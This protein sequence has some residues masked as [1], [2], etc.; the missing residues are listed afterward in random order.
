MTDTDSII[1]RADVR[2]L[3]RKKYGAAAL[4]VLNG[5]GAAC[6]GGIGMRGASNSCCGGDVITGGLYDGVDAA[7][8]PEAA[9]LAS[10][11]CGNPTA[12]A[13]LNAGEIVMDLGSGGGIDVLLS[14]RRVGPTGFAYGLDMTDEM[15]TLAE[16]NKAEAGVVNVAFL[17][18]HI[19]QIP[20]PANTVDVII[21]NCVINLSADKDAVL[22][23]AF[24]VLK[25]SGRFAVSD[26]VVEGELPSA[27]RADMEAYVGCV[28]GALE[29]S[30]YLRRLAAAGFEDASIEP[31]RRYTFADLEATTCCSPDVAALP[32]DEKAALDGRV[33]GAFIR[34]VKPKQG[35][36][37][38]NGS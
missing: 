32:A 19:E 26:V 27:V 23:E 2:A 1:A 16:K 21:S 33:M 37:E 30:D 11:G 13:Q 17:K 7:A 4:T 18:G 12:L 24:R 10:L 20:L 22:R 25:P 29:R 36:C 8:I 34:A 3:V 5:E 38:G 6:C 9:L 14:A 28:A 31:T 15:L 35:C